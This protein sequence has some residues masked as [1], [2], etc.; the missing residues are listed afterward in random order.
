MNIIS[1]FRV[2]SML[3]SM[4]NPAGNFCAPIND[5]TAAKIRQAIVNYQYDEKLDYNGDGKLTLKDVFFVRRRYQHNL[6]NGNQITINSKT[7]MTIITENYDT[8]IDWEF[9]EID[10]QITRAYEITTNK[11]IPATIRAEFENYSIKYIEIEINPFEEAV[12]V[13]E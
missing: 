1:I 6:E 5:N 7:A 4:M 3:F 2:S 9:C 8:P 12:Y 13:K 11:I 10:N